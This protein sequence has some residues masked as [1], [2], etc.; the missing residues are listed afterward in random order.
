MRLLMKK[1]D[2]IQ[3][4]LYKRTDLQDRLE[5]EN[6]GLM[7]EQWQFYLEIKEKYVDVFEYLKDR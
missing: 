7:D 4:G 1:R 6:K 2:F 3:G 5:P